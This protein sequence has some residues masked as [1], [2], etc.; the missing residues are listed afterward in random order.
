MVLSRQTDSGTGSC[1]QSTGGSQLKTRGFVRAL[2]ALDP[3]LGDIVVCGA[4]A[5]YIYRKY[6]SANRDLPTDFT[7]D[8]DCVGRNPI[9]VRDRRTVVQ[10]LEESDFHWVPRGMNTP[11]AACFRWPS[12]EQPEVEIEFLTPKRGSGARPVATLQDGLTAQT[13]WHLDILLD[14]PLSMTI[15]ESSGASNDDSFHGLIRVPK[16]GHFL[17][18]KGLIHNHRSAE[19]KVKDLA[20]VLDVIDSAKAES[21]RVMVM[22]FGI[23]LVQAQDD[24]NTTDYVLGTA[25]PQQES[26]GQG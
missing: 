14:D 11:P 19:A 13:L 8:M 22:D 5:W 2:R 18:Q 20:Y 7:H 3:Y 25:A 17:V 1:S 16:L 26:Q 23:A 24:I 10:A 6:L 12:A 9:P 4:W 15:H 21:G